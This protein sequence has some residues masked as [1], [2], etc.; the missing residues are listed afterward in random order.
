VSLTIKHTSRV[1][2]T[3]LED[4]SKAFIRYRVENG[5]MKLLETYTPPQHRGR[6]IAKQLTK[7]AVELARKNGW[8]IEPVCSYSVYYFI[9]HPEERDILHPKYREMSEEELKKLFKERLEE[10][11]KED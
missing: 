8:L 7:Y 1:I 4:G 6:G 3:K 5:V 10:E 9:K 11:K 2:W